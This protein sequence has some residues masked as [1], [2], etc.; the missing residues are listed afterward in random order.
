MAD[1]KSAKNVVANMWSNWC[2]LEAGQR[3]QVASKLGAVGHVLSIAANLQNI[4]VDASKTLQDAQDAQGSS[5]S[6]TF[7]TNETNA[8]REHEDDVIDAE[9]EEVES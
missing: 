1:T 8:R 6:E 7:E 9:Y 5:E 2:S 4:A 3:S